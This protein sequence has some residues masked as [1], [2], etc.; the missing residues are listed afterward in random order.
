MQRKRMRRSQRLLLGI[1]SIL[2]MASCLR[3]DTANIQNKDI[4]FVSQRNTQI[5]ATIV[6][7]NQKDM[8]LVVMAHGFMGDRSGRGKF[9]PLANQLAQ[10]GIASIRLDFPGNGESEEP[11]TAY[12]LTNMKQDV[13]QA[14]SYMKQHY[15]IDEER[16]GMVGYSMGGRVVSLSLNDTIRAAALWAPAAKDGLAGLADFMGGMD[17]VSAMDAKARID[18]KAIVQQQ[19]GSYVECS[20]RFFE[21]NAASKPLSAIAS[22]HG[23]LFV[24]VAGVDELIPKETTNAVINHAKQIEVLNLSG[25]DHAFEAIDD[26]NG[27]EAKDQLVASTANFLAAQ[28]GR[29]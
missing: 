8:A 10:Q 1:V 20:Q 7:P 28:L 26:R 22:Y 15:R 18:G 14:I 4:T 2:L 25:V 21:E 29:R 17:Q 12:D 11:F 5:H 16:L 9:E 19:D 3:K 13:A 27:Q 23:A 24:A 6:V